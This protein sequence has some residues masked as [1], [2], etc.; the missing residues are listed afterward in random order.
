MKSMLYINE[1]T[2]VTTVHIS[3]FKK[4]NNT[5]VKHKSTYQTDC[6]VAH[7]YAFMQYLNDTRA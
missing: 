5:H 3:L 1:V 7:L 4:I 2:T 6:H